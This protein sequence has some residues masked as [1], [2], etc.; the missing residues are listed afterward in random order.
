MEQ[1]DLYLEIEAYWEDCMKGI[2]QNVTNLF[3]SHWRL[4]Y[5]EEEFLF[6]PFKFPP[7]EASGDLVPPADG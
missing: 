1:I 2:W 3:R 7:T 6:S 5:V 4:S